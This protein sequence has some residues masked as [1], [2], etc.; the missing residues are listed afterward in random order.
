MPLAAVLG[1]CCSGPGVRGVQLSSARGRNLPFPLG[2]ELVKAFYFRGF[3][4]LVVPLS[5]VPLDSPVLLM[6]SEQM[7]PFAG[8]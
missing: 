1:F 4:A 2:V 3:G 7:L 5:R 8:E 6:V